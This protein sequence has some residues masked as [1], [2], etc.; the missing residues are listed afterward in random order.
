MEDDL[1]EGLNPLVAAHLKKR[2]TE[3][4]RANDPSYKFR[5]TAEEAQAEKSRAQLAGMGGVVQGLSQ[6]GT[7]GGKTPD[8]SPAVQTLQNLGEQSVKDAAAR[9]AAAKDELEGEESQ[10]KLM[11]YLQGLQDKRTAASASAT[12][13]AGQLDRENARDAETRR[14]NTAMEG[15]AGRRAAE[16]GAAKQPTVPAGTA[17]NIG[18]YDA[19]MQ[20]IDQLED[21][22]KNK[23]GTFSGVMQMVPGT[24]AS[25]Y[26]DAA[27]IAA[28]SIGSSLEGGK[29]TDADFE[30][31]RRMI[32]GAGDF[33]ETA[34]NKFDQLRAYAKTK[35][36][37]NISGLES[38]GYKTSG[39][40][41]AGDFAPSKLH[42]GDIGKGS[43]KAPE[44]MTPEER[45]EELRMLRG[46]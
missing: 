6:L 38:A 41:K 15:I 10:D 27:K 46:E 30:K 35:M 44:D 23:T 42:G 2:K 39:F 8:A 11:L 24:D 20:Q 1:Y 37:A 7:L 32:P 18:E 40:K 12:A 19:I 33:R 29:L 34:A 43:E 36:N 26:D 9:R 45:A 5:L 14:H 31:Y 3:L 21:E 28:Q 13:R 17:T 16:G 25:Q 4:D 22:W